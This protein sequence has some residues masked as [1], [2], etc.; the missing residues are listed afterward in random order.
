MMQQTK[1]LSI[2]AGVIRHHIDSQK[3]AL[4][5]PVSPP[6]TS[7]SGSCSGSCGITWR[8]GYPLVI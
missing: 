7:C 3:P 4:T 2:K 1:F 5:G 6:S 8:T